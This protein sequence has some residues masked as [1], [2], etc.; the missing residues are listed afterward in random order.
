MAGELQRHLLHQIEDALPIDLAKRF[1]TGYPHILK[2]CRFLEIFK[3]LLIKVKVYFVAFSA[4]RDTWIPTARHDKRTNMRRSILSSKSV[5]GLS[6]RADEAT[7]PEENTTSP[8]MPTPRALDFASR[9]AK[10]YEYQLRTCTKLFR[11]QD[12]RA[13]FQYYK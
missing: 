5:N 13:A 7:P 11:H 3:Q 4:Q 1:W 10:P 8:K 9:F 2:T 12:T 6:P